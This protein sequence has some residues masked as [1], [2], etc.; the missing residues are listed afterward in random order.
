MEEETIAAFGR[1]IESQSISFLPNL[2]HLIVEIYDW[3]ASV[4]G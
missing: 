2:S 4:L 3:L 1:E